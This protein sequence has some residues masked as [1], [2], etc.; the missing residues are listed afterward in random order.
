MKSPTSSHNYPPDNTWRKIKIQP[1]LQPPLLCSFNNIMLQ[2]S[3]FKT[4]SFSLARAEWKAE[5]SNCCPSLAVL[6]LTASCFRGFFFLEKAENWKD[7][8]AAFKHAIP[9]KIIL[10]PCEFL[11]YSTIKNQIK[12][13]LCLFPKHMISLPTG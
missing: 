9:N 3:H 1:L 7:Y 10:K 5:E 12:N 6:I 2:S 11:I 13:N 8:E 4:F